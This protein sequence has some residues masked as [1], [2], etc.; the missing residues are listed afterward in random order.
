MTDDITNQMEEMLKSS[1]LNPNAVNKV[2]SKLNSQI[3]DGVKKIKVG[4]KL[5]S[6]SIIRSKMKLFDLEDNEIGL[7]TSGGFSPSLKV[8]IGIG[9][10]NSE[11]RYDKV[12]S[13]IRK[14][15]EN[16]NIVNLPFIP[17]KYKR[18]D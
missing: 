12:K 3:N 6:N 2:A 14:S 18:G 4:L 13:V 8:S 15:M 9:Y 10:I 17:H 1:G 16:I 11:Y 5:L 7:I